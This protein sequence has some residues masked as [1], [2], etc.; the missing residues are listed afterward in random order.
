MKKQVHY[1]FFFGGI[2]VGF[3]RLVTGASRLDQ[4]CLRQSKDHQIFELPLRLI[5]KAG[6]QTVQSIV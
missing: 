4:K 3:S 6:V 2:L 5:A 1:M